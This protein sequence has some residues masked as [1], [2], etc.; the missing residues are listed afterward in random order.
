MH[1][2]EIFTIKELLEDGKIKALRPKSKRYNME[3]LVL[4]VLQVISFPR[5]VVRSWPT[6]KTVAKFRMLCASSHH[7][8][9]NVAHHCEALQLNLTEG[10]M[11]PD[12][13]M[14]R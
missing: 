1:D 2:Y 7:N 9:L 6:W 8:W 12:F 14:I 11:E 4:E 13:S 5:Q 10:F 3:C